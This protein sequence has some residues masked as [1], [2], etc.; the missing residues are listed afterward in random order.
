MKIFSTLKKQAISFLEQYK[1][2]NPATYAAAQQAIGAILITDGFIGIDNPLGGKKRPGIF[3]TVIGVIFGIIFMLVPTFGGK[4]TNINNMTA[5]T[6]ATVTSVGMS[7]SQPTTNGRSSSSNS[8]S[9]TVRYTVDGKE[10]TKQS[11]ISSGSYCSLSEGQTVT[12]NYD[13]N[14]PGSWVYGVKTISVALWVFFFAGILML[15]S[16]IIT[17]IIR[18]FSIIFGWKLLRNGRKDAANLP[19]GTNLQSIIDEIKQSFTKTAFNFG[20]GSGFASG[21]AATAQGMIGNQPL[22]STDQT[23]QSSIQQGVPSFDPQAR[24]APTNIV[25]SSPQATPDLQTEISPQN[26]PPASEPAQSTTPP[27]NN[28]IIK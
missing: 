26:I 3:G 6:S 1:K 4:I 15:I 10:Y 11:S 20:G 23:T 19:E 7:S 2:E 27:D 24:T 13:P 12:I 22:A 17:F 9:L 14:N 16:S 28:N 18:L 21:I 25:T 8:C 5:T